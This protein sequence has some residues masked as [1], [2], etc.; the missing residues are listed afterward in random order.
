MLGTDRSLTTGA[1]VHVHI[2]LSDIT[3]WVHV[4]DAE[5]NVLV[6]HLI[7]T[8]PMI[9]DDSAELSDLYYAMTAALVGG[10]SMCPEARERI[11]ALRER[12][13]GAWKHAERG[14]E[15]RASAGGTADDE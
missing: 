5:G 9:V 6:N 14:R 13:Y 4:R 1:G 11:S 10:I 7:D 2:R 8:A 3:G 15:R 12:I